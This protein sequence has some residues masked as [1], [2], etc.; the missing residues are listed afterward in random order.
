MSEKHNAACRIY[1]AYKSWMTFKNFK[2]INCIRSIKVQVLFAYTCC[3][4]LTYIFMW[5]GFFLEQTLRQKY[6]LN[7]SPI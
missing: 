6:I 3:K 1:T 2:G 7:D 4:L 5:I